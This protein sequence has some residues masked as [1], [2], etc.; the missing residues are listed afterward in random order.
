M[1][2]RIHQPSL[3]TGPL[4]GGEAPL[5]LA[6]ERMGPSYGG[7]LALNEAFIDSILEETWEPECWQG[8]GRLPNH[9]D[10]L[11][12]TQIVTAIIESSRRGV[13]VRVG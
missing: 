7:V 1:A 12:Q 8:R 10:G 2:A 9:V 3:L 5:A 4:V 6:L 11:R 13:P